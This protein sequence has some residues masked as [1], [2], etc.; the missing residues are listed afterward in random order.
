M[1]KLNK[2]V[3][4]ELVSVG[5]NAKCYSCVVYDCFGAPTPRRTQETW[6]KNININFSNPR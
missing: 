5:A 3:R 6:Q 4:N 1:K 2:K